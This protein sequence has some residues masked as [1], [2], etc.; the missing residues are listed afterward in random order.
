MST[1]LHTSVNKHS[2]A[3]VCRP[4]G[5]QLGSVTCCLLTQ[6]HMHVSLLGT[7]GWV[8]SP[9]HMQG[10]LEWCPG[11]TLWH[12][13]RAFQRHPMTMIVKK[14]LSHRSWK[15]GKILWGAA[16]TL[17]TCLQLCPQSLLLALFEIRYCAG[18]ISGLDCHSLSWVI[19][20]WWQLDIFHVY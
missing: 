11:S 2:S 18:Q 7:P 13:Y 9:D 19:T 16:G 6:V 10:S 12:I 3:R 4:H 1:N 17:L 15:L 5:D 8:T 14:P 20:R